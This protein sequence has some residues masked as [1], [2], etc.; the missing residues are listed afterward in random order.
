MRD[1]NKIVQDLY[2]AYLKKDFASMR[3][4][5]DV[6]KILEPNSPYIKKY[7]GLYQKLSDS[8]TSN[9]YEELKQ[10]KI[11]QIRWKTVK[12]PHCWANLSLSK[13]NEDELWKSSSTANINYNFECTYCKANFL[14]NIK[15]MVPLYLNISV[16]NEIRIEGK[17]YRVSWWVRY[18]GTWRTR[19][20]GRLEYI[21]RILIDSLGDTY[22]LSES[23]AWWNEMGESGIEYQTELSRKIVPEF[24]LWVFDE[25]V[26]SINDNNYEITE[27]C[28][29]RVSEV[30]GE[31]SKSYTIWEEVSTYQFKYS[32][33][34]YVF[35]REE[36][37]TQ[38]E[39]GIYHTW[40]INDKKTKNWNTWFNSPSLSWNLG[41]ILIW[42]F[43][44][45]WIIAFI[46]PFSILSF[47]TKIKTTTL[48]ELTSMSLI[49]ARWLYKV[50]FSDI[51]KEKISESTTR[52]DYWWIKH[53]TK[54]LD[55]LKFKIETQEDIDVL[56]DILSGKVKIEAYQIPNYPLDFSSKTFADYFKN[57]T[58]TNFK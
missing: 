11:I 37:N 19:D 56:K 34:N 41:T 58:I 32:W 38:K 13:K 31:N 28:K 47:E 54:W 50:D 1:I 7:E 42:L 15:G 23:K 25:R 51:Y 43:I 52:Y 18:M 35:E 46:I 24:N 5:I 57:N 45:L 29:V 55:W 36:T 30:Y 20:S 12:C 6:W 40:E 9:W 22:Y 8:N 26:V 16:W 39:I 44:F 33:K 17:K 48:D 3:L 14:W 10:D 2:T 21:E 27:V 53:T 4:L 49:E